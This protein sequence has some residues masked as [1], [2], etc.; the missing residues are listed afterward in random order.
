M[1]LRN[2]IGDKA[3]YR[4]VFAVSVPMMVANAITNFVGLLDNV[5]IGTLG[6]EALA[7]VSIVNQFI[8]IFQLVVFGAVSAASIFTSQFHGSG[9]KEGVVQTFR[10]KAY[11]N[12]VCTGICIAI[13]LLFGDALIDLFL[14]EGQDT[15]NI[16]LAK[17]YAKEYLL[18]MVIGLLPFALTQV[19]GSTMRETGEVLVPMYS[20]IAAVVTNCIGNA[21]LIFGLLG[22]PALGAKGAAIATVLSRFVE[23][24][25]VAIYAHLKNG[26][27]YY[28]NQSLRS[29]R[30]P[31]PLFRQIFAKGIPIMLNEFFWSLAITM[32]NQSFST[33][34]LDVVA[35]QTINTTIWN[36]MSVIYMAVGCSIAIIVGN[37]LGAGKIE[38]AE[39][40][41]VKMRGFC[42]AV[43]AVIGAIMGA[44]S[45]VFP[46]F[47]DASE[48]VASIATFMLIVSGVGMP[49]AAYCHAAYYTLRTGGKVLITVLFDAVW[50]WAVVVP[51]S[52]ILSNFTSM[53]IHPLFA[54]CMLV[55]VFKMLLGVLLLN[56]V[57]WANQLVGTESTREKAVQS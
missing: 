34:G 1:R 31:L 4:R 21:V 56:K 19:Y 33:R 54:I 48:S 39:D 10:F 25:I 37:L 30:I 6:T 2:Y 22:A 17:Q 55:D 43:G 12:I 29:F 45:S 32:R 46:L 18:V 7:G 44:L 24:A 41:A 35:A 26:K 13:F 57:K 5:M 9:D 3:F 53:S 27:C 36:L 49:F 40:A 42:V 50:M 51:L 14:H 20:S 23:L 52:M 11:I 28:A 38:E 8:F 15:G 16:A 47:F